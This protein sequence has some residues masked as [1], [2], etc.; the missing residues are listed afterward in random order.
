MPI[1]KE[2]RAKDIKMLDLDMDELPTESVF[3]VN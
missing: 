1:P 2:E 3:G